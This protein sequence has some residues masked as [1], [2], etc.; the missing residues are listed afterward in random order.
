MNLDDLKETLVDVLTMELIDA[1][2]VISNEKGVMI[3]FENDTFQLNV[4]RLKGE[5]EGEGDDD[6]EG[7]DEDDEFDGD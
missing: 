5:D 3:V 6:D 1:E 4:Q 7:D 2:E